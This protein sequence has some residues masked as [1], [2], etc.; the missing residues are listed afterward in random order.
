M[1]PASP[2]GL[3]VPL[4]FPSILTLFAVSALLPVAIVSALVWRAF[5]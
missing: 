3:F 2:M 4:I 5:F 1:L